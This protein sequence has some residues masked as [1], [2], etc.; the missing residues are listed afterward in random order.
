M[1]DPF[2][3]TGSS[4]LAGLMCG[5]YAV[6]FDIDPKFMDVVDFHIT[7]LLAYPEYGLN[8]ALLKRTARDDGQRKDDDE[9]D[10]EGDGQAAQDEEDF[11]EEKKV[12]RG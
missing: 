12:K 5:G 4:L 10:D 2:A 9:E 6:G 1:V 11:K 7:R 8:S 3:G